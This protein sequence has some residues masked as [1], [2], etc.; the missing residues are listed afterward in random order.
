MTDLLSPGETP[1]AALRRLERRP[2]YVR[3]LETDAGQALLRAAARQAQQARR[4][5]VRA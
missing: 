3:L 4:E 5:A 2:D 1:A